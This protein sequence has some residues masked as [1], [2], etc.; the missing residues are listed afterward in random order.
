[1]EVRYLFNMVTEDGKRSWTHGQTSEV[2]QLQA[3]AVGIPLL[4]RR[5]SRAAYES[6]L[7]ETVSCLRR[8]GIAGGVFGDID[9][10]EH[11]QW[12]ERVCGESGITPHLP[13]WGMTQQSILNMFV[14]L[15]FRAIVVA[16]RGDF[17]GEDVLG[18]EV[19]RQFIAY[20]EGLRETK[21]LTLC[22]EAGEYHTFVVDGPLFQKGLRLLSTEKDSSDG[23]HILR[24]KD[25]ELVT[26]RGPS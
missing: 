13:L 23:N 15:G 21:G 14:E 22:G 16:A 7:K 2:L 25:A 11:R 17:F 8:Q 3:E 20:L 4:Q 6:E 24:I 18:R 9:L 1:M 5:S 26:K 10:E 19:D 12:V